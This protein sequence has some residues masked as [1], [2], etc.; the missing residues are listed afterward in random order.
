MKIYLTILI[1]T[2]ILSS[3]AFTQPL[4]KFSLDE[5]AI[6]DMITGNTLTGRST[7]G[8]FFSEYHLADGRVLGDNGY[9]QNTDAC[10]TVQ[11]NQICYYY[12]EGANRTNH[13][14]KFEKS[15]DIISLKFTPPNPR[16]GNLDAFA[17][18]EK[19]NPRNH[20][21]E[22]KTWHCDG[23]VSNLIDAKIILAQAT[24]LST[25]KPQYDFD[26]LT[27]TGKYSTNKS[28]IKPLE[29][30]AP[31]L[32]EAQS[33]PK[34]PLG[35][36]PRSN[37]LKP[38]NLEAP[39]NSAMPQGDMVRPK[40][41]PGQI[42]QPIDKTKINPKPNLIASPLPSTQLPSVTLPQKQVQPSQFQPSQVQPNQYRPVKSFQHP[43]PQFR[44]I[45]NRSQV[46]TAP[47]ALVPQPKFC[48][49]GKS[50]C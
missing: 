1:I 41:P 19:G 24:P 22:G 45:P 35:A 11:K 12:G 26:F 31:S 8:R 38:N 44:A 32:R 46:I 23:L 4:E 36:I 14:F 6:R 9:Y 29:I 47:K 21:D 20:S 48:P 33:T 37:E 25:N 39:K 49:T 2:N 34:T 27:G 43:Q 28:S 7:E 13:C 40:L 15:H 10:W 30:G 50:G 5:T 3:V 17:K 42:P 16:A 18:I